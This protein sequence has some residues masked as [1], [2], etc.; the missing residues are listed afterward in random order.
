MKDWDRKSLEIPIKLE[1]DKKHENDLFY[2]KFVYAPL[3]K[4]YGVTLGTAIR[5]TLL[6]SLRGSAISAIKVEG[7]QHEFSTVNGVIEDVTYI[8][9]NIKEVKFNYHEDRPLFLSLVV[10]GYSDRERIV[11][12]SDIE[13][14]GQVS[15]MNPDHK[16]A[17]L[18]P[19]GKLN[20]ELFLTMGKGY[21]PA[22][23]NKANEN[24]FD[25]TFIAID[26]VYS[27]IKKVNFNVRNARKGTRT[28]YDKLVIEV[29]TNGSILPVD[30]ISKS[31][32]ILV[33][34]L[35]PFI[36]IEEDEE[37][38]IILDLSVDE[39]K[40]NE[41]NEAVYRHLDELELSFRSANC[42]KKANIR[43]IGELIQKS[44]TELLKIKNFGRKSLMEIREIVDDLG[45][46]LGKNYG[47]KIEDAEKFKK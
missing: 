13:L 39:S 15:I 30:A 26:A 3:E 44:E 31:A 32:K 12:A 33:E 46:E 6:S 24:L 22:D 19:G 2:G 4:G 5:R 14:P 10:D 37:D 40:E 43:Y 20:I 18:A 34:F 29:W 28:D 36:N 11:R 23:E 1:Y 7:A 17:T 47:F 38:D 27:P 42:L 21:V 41:V 25:D 16:I 9:L 45:L 35:N 8:I